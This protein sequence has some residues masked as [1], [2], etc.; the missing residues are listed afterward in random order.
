[1]FVSI[2][3]VIARAVHGPIARRPF[4]RD[5]CQGSRCR[6][7]FKMDSWFVRAGRELRFRLSQR[8]ACRQGEHPERGESRGAL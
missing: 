5:E 6:G 2:A 7:I 1:M 8:A 4:C 3:V